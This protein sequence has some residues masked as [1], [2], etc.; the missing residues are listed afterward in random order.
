MG[1]WLDSPNSDYLCQLLQQHRESA[2]LGQEAVARALGVA[3]SYVCDYEAAR[4]R[5]DFFQ[6]H[7]IA[8]TIGTTR[9]S[10]LWDYEQHVRSAGVALPRPLSRAERDALV[11]VVPPSHGE[12]DAVQLG[13]LLEALRERFNPKRRQVDIGRVLGRPQSWVS[14]YEH[15][16]V[17]LDVIQL[18]EVA[19]AVKVT[20]SDLDAMLTGQ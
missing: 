5:L 16:A 2:G 15:G 4:K 19:A 18:E 10:V 7:W 6:L 8:V 3:Q 17:R 1:A 9:R 14:K 13:L 11:A 12:A 20:L